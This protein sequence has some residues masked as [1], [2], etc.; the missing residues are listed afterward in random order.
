[1]PFVRMWKS[2][3]ESGRPQMTIWLLRIAC[4]ITRA[5]DTFRLCNT[6]G[7]SNAAV[8]ARTRFIVTLYVH[9]LFCLIYLLKIAQIK[10]VIGIGFRSCI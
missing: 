4:W 1:L 8:V 2:I 5:T 6:Y 9:S 7:F 3:V 10:R